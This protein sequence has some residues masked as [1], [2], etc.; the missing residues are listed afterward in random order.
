ML[1]SAFF[2]SI[3]S[4]PWYVTELSEVYCLL[5]I[6]YQYYLITKYGLNKKTILLSSFLIS[7]SSLVNQASVIF[8]IGLAFLVFFDKELRSK[9]NNYLYLGIGF[10]TPHLF[11]IVIYSINK[12]LNVYLTNYIKIPFGYVGSG[13]F[14]I[15]ELVVWLK[16]FYL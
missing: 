9:L 3:T 7:L 1:S 16:I 4:H 5:F 8:L 12:L 6:T 15:Y 11:F 14:D 13:K 2:I 10:L